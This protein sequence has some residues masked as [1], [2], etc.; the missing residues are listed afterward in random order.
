[1]A[2]DLKLEG[3]FKEFT[4]NYLQGNIE[5]GVIYDAY[6]VALDINDFVKNLKTKKIDLIKL[7]YNSKKKWVESFKNKVILFN[8]NLLHKS[9]KMHNKCVRYGKV[10]KSSNFFI[11]LYSTIWD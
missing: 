9:Q 10:K 3:F 7:A 11:F 2:I 1:M 8:Y 5:F 4:R 6:M